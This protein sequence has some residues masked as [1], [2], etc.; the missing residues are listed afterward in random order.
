MLR[1]SL[2]ECKRL[3]HVPVHDLKPIVA[4]PE[5]DLE[6]L[7][8]TGRPRPQLDSDALFADILDQ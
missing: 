4:E 1:D 2:Q 5:S 7:V 3:G 6:P 8:G